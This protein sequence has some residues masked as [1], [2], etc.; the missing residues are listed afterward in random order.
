MRPAFLFQFTELDCVLLIRIVAGE[1]FGEPRHRL[2]AQL[3]HTAVLTLPRCIRTTSMPC[4][5]TFVVAFRRFHALRTV[6]SNLQLDGSILHAAAVQNPVQRINRFLPCMQLPCIRTRMPSLTK[7]KQWL[8][9][10]SHKGG[11]G[12]VMFMLSSVWLRGPLLMVIQLVDRT[13]SSQ[14]C[15]P[16]RWSTYECK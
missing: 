16:W 7:Q 10:S 4:L 13:K 1:E 9:S 2:H 3:P 14:R 6:E 15:S 12:L 11:G 5:G 8:S